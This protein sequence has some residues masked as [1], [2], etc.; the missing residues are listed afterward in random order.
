MEWKKTPAF[1]STPVRI[2]RIAKCPPK[3]NAESRS[4]KAEIIEHRVL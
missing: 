1:L 3:T 2:L 4:G